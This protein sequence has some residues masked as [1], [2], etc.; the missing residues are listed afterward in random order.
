MQRILRD[1]QAMLGGTFESYQARVALIHRHFPPSI[2]TM[3]ATPRNGQADTLEWWTE[4]PGQPTRFDALVG[5]Q[6]VALLERYQQRQQSL[7]R[8]ADE[9][10][11]RGDSDGGES[12]K[13]L[14]GPAETQH[15][16]SLNG[17]PVVIRWGADM[18]DATAPS[19][20]PQ[21]TP[22]APSPAPVVAASSRSR[23]R[24]LTWLL[25][26]LLFLLLALGVLL[27]LLWPLDRYG[28][29]WFKNASGDLVPY[30]CLEEEKRLPPE[31]VLIFD[32]SGSMNINIAATQEDEE[33]Y[34]GMNEFRQ[35]MLRNRG[36]ERLLALETGT[37]R[38]EVAKDSVSRI[39][40]QLHPDIDTGLITYAGCG[41]PVTQGVFKASQREQLVDGI[42]ALNAYDGTPLAESLVAAAE[43]VDGRE[44]D[45]IIIAFV[46]GADGCEQDQCQIAAEI[47]QNQPRLTINVVDVTTGG[48]SNCLA[49]HTGGQVFSSQDAVEITSM[50][51]QASSQILNASHCE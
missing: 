48:R 25:P 47:A 37:S 28:F 50:L 32:T 1:T 33:W 16:Y 4:L 20:T 3:Y 34:F 10:V 29:N 38:L 22:M 23:L 19:V 5:E 40:T 36:N 8:L 13:T 18:V 44:R 11:R 9:L 43:L 42:Q 30:A 31:F 26:L 6:Q 35:I 24:T 12:L 41:S 21:P 49:K 2:G 46:D 27:Y 45:A 14:I 39:I 7:E 51:A 15:L 17:E